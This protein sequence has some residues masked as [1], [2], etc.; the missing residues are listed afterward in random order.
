M[1]KKGSEKFTVE[2]AIAEGLPPGWTKEIR[3]KKKGGKTRKDPYYI[4]PESGQVFRSLKEVFRY[5]GT[6]DCSKAEPELKDQ[7]PN[8]VE[9]GGS[10]SSIS[11]NFWSLFPLLK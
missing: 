4:A 3:V 1:K 10:L 5:L 2:K 11:T 6:K 7:G 9:A 8:N